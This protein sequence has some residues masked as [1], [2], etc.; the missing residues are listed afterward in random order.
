MKFLIVLAS[1]VLASAMHFDPDWVHSSGSRI[2]S[3]IDYEKNDGIVTLTWDGIIFSTGDEY[4]TG[5][6]TQTPLPDDI[7]PKDTLIYMI[8]MEKDGLF[9]SG[10][11]TIGYDGVLTLMQ[12]N[13]L[14][15]EPGHTI[16]L[17]RSSVSY[18]LG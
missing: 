7:T 9:M 3:L 10:L 16:G 6:K 8:G 12:Y 17:Y 14:Q 4:I 18:G 13:G 5:I 11:L 15:F 2:T 1:V